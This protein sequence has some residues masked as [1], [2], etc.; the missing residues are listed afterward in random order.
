M[1]ARVRGGSSALTWVV[2]CVLRALFPELPI[3]CLSPALAL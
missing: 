1:L 3:Q 2:L